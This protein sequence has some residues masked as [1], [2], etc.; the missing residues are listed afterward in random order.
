MPADLRDSILHFKVRHI[1]I[2]IKE[3]MNN[4]WLKMVLFFMLALLW[5]ACSVEN[6]YEVISSENILPKAEGEYDYSKDSLKMK[7]VERSSFEGNLRQSV[8]KISF[9]GENI[10]KKREQLFMPNRLGYAEKNETY[11]MLDSIPFHL[12]EWS[13]EDS[14][15]TVNAFYNWLDCFGQSCNSIRIDEEKNGSKE[16]FVIWISNTRISYLASNQRINRSI[17]QETI[18][19]K[20]QEIWNYIIQQAPR[21]K[22]NWVVSVALEERE[23][24]E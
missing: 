15:K 20:E 4:Q 24:K 12:I 23:V 5:N 22:M 6:D 19:G 16:A 18:F 9:E 10:L 2:D 1:S 3:N 11:F 14:L 7:E 13:F 17:W 8:P 21:G